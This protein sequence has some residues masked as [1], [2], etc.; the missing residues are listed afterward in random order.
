MFLGNEARTFWRYFSRYAAVK[1]STGYD[2]Y[3]Y[4]TERFAKGDISRRLIGWF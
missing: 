1:N 4:W 2:V 3:G